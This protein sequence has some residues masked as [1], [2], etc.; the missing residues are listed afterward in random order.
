[1]VSGDQLLIPGGRSVPACYDRHTGKLLRYQLA[2][3]G[4]KGGGSDVTAVGPWF[5]NGGGAF[6]GRTG[7]FLGEG[8]K[9]VVAT[10]V[11]LYSVAKDKLKV[12]DLKKAEVKDVETVDRK[13]KKTK[14]SKWTAT[15]LASLKVPALDC[16]IKAGSQLVAGS[17]S[18]ILG[19]ALSGKA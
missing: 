18:D 11:A 2:E 16:L 9:P 7:E 3:N 10:P 5:F 8:R 1:V 19:I 15:E 6:A 17:G 4:K 12:F 13:G 14:T